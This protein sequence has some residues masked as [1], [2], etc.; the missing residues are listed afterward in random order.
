MAKQE[1]TYS[2]AYTEL[3]KIVSQIENEEI[4]IDK[5]ADYVKRASELLTF[6]K[7]KLKKSEKEIVNIMK[8]IEGDK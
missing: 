7:E 8:D 3:E 5:L 6:C 1:L 2:K 4:E